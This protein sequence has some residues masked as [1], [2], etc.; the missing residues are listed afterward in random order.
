MLIPAIPYVASALAAIFAGG[1]L[2]KAK[3]NAKI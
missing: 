3:E 2:G 1:W